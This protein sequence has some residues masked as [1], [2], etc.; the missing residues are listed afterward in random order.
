MGEIAQ[1]EGRE[2]VL[3]PVAAAED[4]GFLKQRAGGEALERLDEAGLGR[5]LH[6]GLDGPRTGLDRASVGLVGVGME[7]QR[8]AEG[9]EL[10][11]GVGKADQMR[12]A[13]GGDC[14]TTVLVVPKSMPTVR[15]RAVRM[16]FRPRELELFCPLWRPPR[17]AA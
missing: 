17:G 4:V 3:E 14:E 2:Q 15:R 8:R 16:A 6:I 13:V 1:Q 7:A 11:V 9:E 12:R 5:V 10:A